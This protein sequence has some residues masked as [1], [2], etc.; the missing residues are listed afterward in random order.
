[1]KVLVEIDDELFSRMKRVAKGSLHNFILVSIEN[2]IAIE[3]SK[4]SDILDLS[5]TDINTRKHPSTALEKVLIEKPLKEVPGKE[6]ILDTLKKDRISF[7]RNE[8]TVRNPAKPLKNYFIWGQYNK[9]FPIKFS[10]RYLAEMQSDNSNN[11]ILLT[12]FQEKC[13]TAATEMKQQLLLNDKKYDRIWG[14]NFSAGF[15]DLNPDKKSQLRFIHHFIGYANSQGD[16]VGSLGDYGF[17]IIIKDKIYF[18]PSGIQFAELNNPILDED[19]MGEQLLSTEER[20]FLNEYMKNQLPR[21]WDGIM[22]II[23]WIS[24]G[25]NTPDSLNG[26]IKSLDV[27]GKWTDKM[28]NTMRTGF[29]GRMY[30]MDLI[31]R[32]KKGN[33]SVY[34]VT[35]AGKRVGE[36]I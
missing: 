20:E 24:Q 33:K 22:K 5:K 9:I 26:K 23:K 29:L 8:N 18:T 7:V 3:E 16:T 30:D 35:D 11:A 34:F 17:A 4:S 25:S 15:P 31:Y 21:D 28:V 1:M 32:E 14:E 27:E 36:I 12:T 2:Q 6:N 13:S 19:P 10:L